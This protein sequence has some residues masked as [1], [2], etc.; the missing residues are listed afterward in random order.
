MGHRL[1]KHEQNELVRRWHENHEQDAADLICTYIQD[2]LNKYCRGNVDPLISQEIIQSTLF[3]FTEIV[4]HGKW[5]FEGTASPVT[6]CNKVFRYKFCDRINKHKPDYKSLKQYYE[7]LHKYQSPD[8]ATDP[9]WI[10][11]EW[12]IKY[13]NELP[14]SN[15]EPLRR[16]FL[17]RNGFKIEDNR[18][19]TTI[20]LKNEEIAKCFGFQRSWASQQYNKAHHLLRK[21]MSEDNEKR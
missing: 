2:M 3:A 5:Q 11:H 17:L 18:L 7:M 4:N 16:V 8:K 1:N 20:P 19:I 6:W 13:L 15:K 14:D 12:L 9:Q 21:W 10:Q